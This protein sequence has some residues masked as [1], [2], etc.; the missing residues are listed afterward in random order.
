MSA[1]HK[2]VILIL[3]I[4][5]VVVCTALYASGPIA[6]FLSALICILVY[7]LRPL[8]MPAGYGANKIRTLC[9]LGSLGLVT[10][11]GAWSET[12]NIM[13][14][15]IWESPQTSGVPIWIRSI[16]LNGQPSFYVLA[17]VFGVIFVVNYFMRDRSISGGH[18][19]P[20][21][22]DFPEES[23]QKKLESFC[24]ALN[25]DLITIDRASNWSPEYYTEL[26][27][28]VE[29]LSASGTASRRKI[30]N[31]QEAIRK[32]RKSQSFLILGVPGSGKSVA[33]RKLA[34]DMLSEAAKTN[35]VPI[36]INLREWVPAEPNGVNH[37]RFDLKNLE[38]FVIE[39][40][41]RRGDVFTEEF[42]DMYFRPL[43]R[44]G[45]LF[46]IF[47][48]FDEIS[49]LLDA[50]E[51]SEVINSL[52]SVISRFISS[53]PAS[54]GV[55]SS[56]VFRRP[57]QSFLAQKVLEIRPLSESSISE[58]L[59]RY[60]QFNDR[61]R[62]VLFRDRLDLIP[63]ARN[64]FIMAL[65]GAWVKVK[66][67]LPS[68]QAQIYEG[69]IRNRLDSCSS[70][71]KNAGVSAQEVLDVSTEVAWFVFSSSAF[72]LEAPVKVISDHFKSSKVDAVLEIL[73]YARIARVTRGDDKSFAFVHRRFLEYFVT[74]RLLLNPAEVPVSHIPTD[75]RGRDAL[76]LYAQLCEEGE[77][78][79][80]ANLC[81][82]E[83]Q[84][85]F[86]HV[87]LRIRAIHCLRFLIDA[88]CSRRSVI[89]PF[90]DEL[91]DFVMEHVSQ[92]D[93]IILAKICLEAT[94]LLSASKAAP[95]LSVAIVGVDGWLQETA[96][97]SCRHL[98]KMEK[99]LE[100]SISSYVL[101]IPDTN[102]W[103]N[104][105]SILLSLSLSDALRNVYRD[106]RIRLMNIKLSIFVA[107]VIMVAIPKLVLASLVYAVI[108]SGTIRGLG[109]KNSIRSIFGERVSS[110]RKIQTLVSPKILANKGFF[111]A[112]VTIFR[113]LGCCALVGIS[114]ILLYSNSS[115][116]IDLLCTYGECEGYNSW[117]AAL[118]IALGLML[119]DW[120]LVV[121]V[122]NDLFKELFN[123]TG[124]VV[125]P[126]MSGII[127][128][129]LLLIYYLDKYLSKYE[130][131]G[132][133]LKSV[134]WLTLTVVAIMAAK[135]IITAARD[136]IKDIAMIR[137]LNIG[138]SITRPEISETF[139]KLLTN[140]GKLLYVR[141]LEGSRAVVTGVWPSDFK[142]AVGLGEGV[143]ALA[144]L[145][146]RWLKLD[147]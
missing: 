74:V 86:N 47:D 123:R 84:E 15:A 98:P 110:G 62:L 7:M 55:L 66:Q 78:K 29:V 136:Y 129:M 68:S 81:W 69:Y 16:R 52:S 28:E 106:A 13:L 18:P 146:E 105:K 38:E 54:R 11:W 72:G 109:A 44:S 96:F 91:S 4:A 83:I 17:F 97:R 80:I 108:L 113:L 87:D 32:D 88:F 36:Y 85:N 100:E 101:T 82:R 119:L 56:R 93:S 19:T 50:D 37:T 137:S 59:S 141:N 10:S 116:T 23:F 147:R 5:T 95:I 43:W 118:Y 71:L 34:R 25:Q 134:F 58:A 1:N 67:E 143:S 45:R 128:L 112:L 24:S 142:L 124:L 27:A 77:A 65:L 76:V 89:L 46:F 140:H 53:H 35:R 125:L 121:K 40:V 2:F 70:R 61:L 48:S 22:K 49:E 60:P 42:V 51:D 94:G 130:I 73:D 9:I 99:N 63:L 64:P 21:E 120:V 145:E 132:L 133:I 8:V 30:V 122:S 104:R 144:R 107:A 138:L 139:S 126:L 117:L 3:L 41:K 39:N 12:V 127:G 79:R 57:T 102:F 114:L 103:S 26:Q 6:V 115:E 14:S 131:L 92:G 33:L 90:E 135:K 75:S 31:L 111:D 20:L